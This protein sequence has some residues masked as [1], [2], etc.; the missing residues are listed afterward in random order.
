MDCIRNGSPLTVSLFHLQSGSRHTQS[1]AGINFPQQREH[2]IPAV[3]LHQERP[4]DSHSDVPPRDRRRSSPVN[5]AGQS[6][7]PTDGQVPSGED[8]TAAHSR[9]PTRYVSRR[10][11]SGGS[12]SSGSGGEKAPV[13]GGHD[14][15][16]VGGP[17]LQ[18][19]VIDH[20]LSDV[21]SQAS[22]TPQ[23][24][25]NTRLLPRGA[26]SDSS[27]HFGSVGVD[28]FRGSNWGRDAELGLPMVPE[29]DGPSRLPI[30]LGDFLG[31]KSAKPQRMRAEERPTF[32]WVRH[33]CRLILARHPGNQNWFYCCCGPC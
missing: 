21:S 24:S 33:P 25:G 13:E 17:Q 3:G 4:S 14:N 32:Q 1:T 19:I 12:S 8:S 18:S 5:G 2:N 20:Q 11:H 31:L 7:G 28:S 10:T 6:K 15:V 30:L 9:R 26:H 16:L 29:G 23:H 22:P 27:R